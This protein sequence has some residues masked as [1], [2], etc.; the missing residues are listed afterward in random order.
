[1]KQAQEGGASSRTILRPAL[2]LLH[3]IYHASSSSVRLALHSAYELA[4]LISWHKAHRE[5][6]TVLVGYLGN[7]SYWRPAD[8]VALEAMY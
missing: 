8:S 5:S 7:Y 3:C 4:K 1:M 2:P 6:H